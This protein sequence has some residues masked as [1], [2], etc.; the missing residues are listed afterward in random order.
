MSIV[1][2]YD[3]Q[4]SQTHSL[5]IGLDYFRDPS[6][7]PY[8][9]PNIP[10]GLGGIHLGYR[11][12]IWRLSLGLQIGTYIT[13]SR[14]KEAIFLRPSLRYDISSRLFAQVGLKTHKGATADWVEWGLGLK[15]FR[16]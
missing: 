7:N 6:L 9:Q 14:G 13:S 12:R 5:G 11:H 4:L 16:F 2:D 10:I 3:Y 8:S 15:L 1:L